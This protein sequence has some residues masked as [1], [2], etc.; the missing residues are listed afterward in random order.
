[1]I[2]RVQRDTNEARSSL[3]SNVSARRKDVLGV[4]GYVVSASHPD[5]FG[6]ALHAGIFAGVRNRILLSEFVSHRALAGPK[7]HS[8]P[9][10]CAYFE[11]EGRML[12]EFAGI[13][14]ATVC[15]L[16]SDL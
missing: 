14:C 13:V 7:I 4:R 15:W 2:R 8:L 1:M 3:S 16:F 11:L 5:L 9:P 12:L 6:R 10:S